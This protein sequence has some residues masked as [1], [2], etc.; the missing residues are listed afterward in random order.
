VTTADPTHISQAEVIVQH[1]GVPDAWLAQSAA[2]IVWMVHGRPLACFRPEQNGTVRSYS[3]YASVAQDP[4]VKAMVY[5][6]PEFT[7]FWRVIFPSEKLVSLPWPPI[8]EARFRPEGPR[9]TIEDAHRGD[10]NGLICDSWREDIDVF[11]AMNGAIE[12]ARLVPGLKWHLYGFEQPLSECWGYL[13]AEL[14]RL[15]ALG[16]LRAR[17]P[18]MEQVY[19][20]MDFLLTP[21][22]IV[23][24][25]TGEALSCGLPIVAATSCRV[26]QETADMAEPA[27]VGAAVGR[28]VDRLERSRVQVRHQALHEAK[29]FGLARFSAAMAPIY[30]RATEGG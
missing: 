4:R 2:P 29:H 24:R 30:E 11:E 26:A 10:F 19:R 3:M 5:F 28:L 25:I 23:T 21:H 17:M 6:W 22:R 8:D 20:G 9:H 14:R 16:E 27:A 7:P 15:G 13:I 12:A 1:T 18:N